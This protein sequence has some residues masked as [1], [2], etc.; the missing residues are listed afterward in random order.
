MLRRRYLWCWQLNLVILLLPGM[1]VTFCKDSALAGILPDRSW[2]AESSG[3]TP[4]HVNLNN[5]FAD[6][7]ELTVILSQIPSPITPRSPEQPTPRPQPLPDA[8]LEVPPLEVPT[9][10]LPSSEEPPNIPGTQTIKRFEFEGNTAF[11]DEDLAQVTK[12]FTGEVTFAELLQAEAAVTKY[13]SDAG[14]LNSGAFIPAGQNIQEQDGVVKMQIIEGAVEEIVV[15]GTQRLKQSYIRS[16]LA[17]ATRAPLNRDRLL[18]ALQLLQLNPLMQNISAKLSAGSRPELSVLTVKVTEAD[19]FNIELFTNNGRVPSVGS[20]RRGLRLNQGNLFGL[21]DRLTGEY[22]NT[23]GSNAFDGR[24][25]L[26]LN[27]RNGALILA[28]GLNDTEIVEPPFDRL[29]LTGNYYYLEL[30]FQQPIIQTPSQELALGLTAFRQQSNTELDGEGFPLSA[31]ANDQGE[32]RISALRLVQEYTQRSQQAVLAVRSQFSLGLDIFNA[33]VNEDPPD[34]RFFAWQGQGQY[35]RLLF[36]DSLLVVRSDLQFSTRALVPLERFSLGGWQSV[37]GY[38][39]DA[40][41]TDNGVFASAEV[42]LPILRVERVQGVLQVVPF[43]D[44][45]I[46]WNS[47]DTP[48]PDPNSLV[49]VGLGLQ[50][51]MG[52]KLTA[53]FDWGIPLI[54]IEDSD[55]TLQEKGLY[56][57][58]NYSPF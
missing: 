4:P 46:G 1:S 9:P 42:R 3:L 32:T 54:D 5:Q 19:S 25:E 6:T 52:D 38:R 11:S 45:G 39:Q 28:G 56:F 44:F 20:W 36:P 40:L 26:P 27:P 49:G 57:S 16:R 51:Q 35:V 21:G 2:G 17:I 31:G 47:S 24:Y 7:K 18:E 48:D 22:A 50:W 34:S 12:R 10:K 58:I 23:D 43:V 37:R 33:T 8:P 53:R 14:Y 15:T 41:L 13:Y 30:G 55:R 29:N